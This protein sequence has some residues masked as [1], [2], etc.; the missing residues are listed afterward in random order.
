MHT[1][2]NTRKFI[3]K[4]ISERLDGFYVWIAKSA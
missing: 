3:L 4:G 2:L 1:M